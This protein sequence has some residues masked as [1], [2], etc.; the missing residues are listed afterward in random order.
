ML[1]PTIITRKPAKS[2]VNCELTYF[3]RKPIDHERALAQHQ[4]YEAFFLDNGWD[5]VSLPSVEEF[6]DSTFVEDTVVVFDEIAILLSPAASSRRGEVPLIKPTILQFRKTV[7]IRPPAFIDGGDV[8][9]IGKTVFVGLSTRTNR[10]GIDALKE[11]LSPFDYEVI[12]VVVDGALHLKTA[13]TA[14]DEQTLLMNPDWVDSRKF[15]GF[16][17]IRVPHEEPSSANAIRV[18]EYVVLPI[19]RGMHTAA[20]IRREGFRVRTLDISEFQKAE[21][22]LS[23]LGVMVL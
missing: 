15:E 4:A 19:E 20:L 21:A 8:L 13:C 22:G 10:E 1:V 9:T 2:L 3:N 6:P 12:P 16:H 5:V 23:C 11:I 14:L 18:D 7:E 17:I